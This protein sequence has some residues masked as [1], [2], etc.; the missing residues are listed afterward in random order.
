[1]SEQSDVFIAHL[2]FDWSRLVTMTLALSNTQYLGH[3]TQCVCLCEINSLVKIN[4]LDTISTLTKSRLSCEMQRERERVCSK[5]FA[6][7]CSDTLG[8][9]ICYVN[10]HIEI[11]IALSVVCETLSHLLGALNVALRPHSSW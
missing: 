7:S 3:I 5:F 1:M 2:S 8:Q 10:W 4:S 11:C 9:S 6:Q